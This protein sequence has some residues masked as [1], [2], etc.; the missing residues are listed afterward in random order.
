MVCSSRRSDGIGVHNTSRHHP[1]CAGPPR[2][3]GQAPDSI[4]P[5]PW[6]EPEPHQR[7]LL[8]KK[9]G[10]PT[11]LGQFA[12]QQQPPSSLSG[13]TMALR[14]SHSSAL[15]PCICR[16]YSS[17]TTKTVHTEASRTRPNV[18]KNVNAT[19]TPMRQQMQ[20]SQK[21]WTMEYSY[22]HARATKTSTETPTILHIRITSWSASSVA[23]AVFPSL[24]MRSIIWP[25]A[26]RYEW[27]F[28]PTNT[29]ANAL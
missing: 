23:I 21:S 20:I 8:G 17:N 9:G 7:L 28:R 11:T 24:L 19:T 12:V 25:A 4:L 26:P 10:F 27:P 15:A 5:A 1:T 13:F 16:G 2:P 6:P 22:P 29:K 14:V 3:L 18:V